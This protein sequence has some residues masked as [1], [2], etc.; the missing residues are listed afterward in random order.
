MTTVL[1]VD[2]ASRRRALC[3]LAGDGGVLLAARQLEGRQLDRSLP[4]ALAELLARGVPDAVAVVMGPGSYTGLRVGIAA[5]LGLAHARDLPLHGVAALEVVA[6]AA[7]AEAR[8]VE[9]V[10]DAGRGALYV[11]RYEREGA[12]LRLRQAPRRVETASWSPAAGHVAVGF[13]AVPGAMHCEDRAAAALA[14]SAVAALRQP[15]L[16]RAG[17][18][19]LYL[20]GG[21]SAATE[22]RV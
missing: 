14:E 15:P 12:A 8:L 17:L 18:E 20:S 9:A 6:R 10:A 1:A 22:P 2:T 5:A 13:D 11:A 7:P 3:V 16:P 4:A 19:P 21:V